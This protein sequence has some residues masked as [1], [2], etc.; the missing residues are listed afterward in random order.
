MRYNQIDTSG[1]RRNIIEIGNNLA[2]HMHQNDIKNIIFLDRS[3][4]PGYIALKEAWKK[5]FPC[6]KRPNIYFTNPEGYARKRKFAHEASAEL[7]RKR[8]QE[9]IVEFDKIYKKLAYDKDQSIMVFDVCMHSGRAMKPIFNTL[10]IA[11]YS[12]VTVGLT[13]PKDSNQRYASNDIEINFEALDHVPVKLCYPF[14]RDEIVEKRK[15]HIL[16]LKNK[17]FWDRKTS[18]QL[19]KEISSLF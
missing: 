11:G 7:N 4:R 17:D 12:N 1:K 6:I 9:N 15:T 19:R 14:T 18:K 3:A 8:M 16:S 10:K 5:K 2:E 13:Q